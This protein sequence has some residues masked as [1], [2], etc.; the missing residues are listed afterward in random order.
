[1]A[2]IG[3]YLGVR[4]ANRNVVKIAREQRSS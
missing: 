2:I 3:G 1:M 4:S